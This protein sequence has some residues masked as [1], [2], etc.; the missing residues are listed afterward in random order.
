MDAIERMLGGYRAFRA[1]MPEDHTKKLRALVEAGQS[2]QAA[3]IA[4]SDS[5]V[6][7]GI[8][9]PKDRGQD[10]VLEP[11]EVGAGTGEPE[12]EAGAP[13]AIQIAYW[14]KN[15]LLTQI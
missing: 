11:P 6:D 5:R 1:N 14:L 7:P 10:P 15:D 9:D 2:P 12:S 13:Q 4:C 3:V 8:S